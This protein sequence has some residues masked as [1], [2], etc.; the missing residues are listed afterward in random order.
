[1]SAL[2]GQKKSLRGGATVASP[3]DKRNSEDVVPLIIDCD[4]PH[5]AE[6]A[7]VQKQG[8][9]GWV[10]SVLQREKKIKQDDNVAGRGN[11]EGLFNVYRSFPVKKYGKMKRGI[12]QGI[13]SKVF[14]YESNDMVYAVKC[15]VKKNLKDVDDMNAIGKEVE[16]HKGVDDG[17]HVVRLVESFRVRHEQFCVVLE[18]LPCTLQALYTTYGPMLDQADRLCYFK[19]VAE[20]LYYLQSNG[21]GHR[22]IKLENCGIDPQGDLKLFDFGSATMGNVGYGMAG[23]PSY[24]APEIH[25]QLMYDSFKC[26]V[27][28]LGILLINLFY[29]SKQKWKNARH[30]D[31]AFISY[32]RHPTLEN[33]V[34]SVRRIANDQDPQYVAN[35]SPVDSL[36]LQLLT[37]NV[38][39]RIDL[40]EL[41]NNHL[42]FQQIDCCRD[43]RGAGHAHLKAV[44]RMTAAASSAPSLSPCS[45]VS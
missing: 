5:S 8:S 12:G 44:A 31:K 1:M 43:R 16:I 38:D 4:S 29:V 2:A 41:V 17:Y 32:R 28:S 40:S 9:M 13:S 19:Q 22:D 42:W 37:V 26:D 30:D 11:R 10:R 7:V 25:A 39:H 15:F 3:A 35:K 36:I 23:S 27:W 45:E 6:L 14:L 20:G 18:Y 24:A 33:A 21:I 34:V